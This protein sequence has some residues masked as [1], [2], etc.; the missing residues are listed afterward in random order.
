MKNLKDY[1][2]EGI[3]DNN[4]INTMDEFINNPFFNCYN[5]WKDYKEDSTKIPHD[6]LLQ[7]LSTLRVPQF[8]KLDSINIET[9]KYMK[10]H[11]IINI[12][13]GPYDKKQHRLFDLTFDEENYR[14]IVK[15]SSDNDEIINVY[16][17]FV[18][19]K[20]LCDGWSKI[21]N[22]KY[23]ESTINGSISKF[24]MLVLK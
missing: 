9:S 12:K 23:I 6:K 10:N 17:N 4:T 14:V 2:K 16:G 5:L 7:V 19:F 22:T 21:Y 8:I 3:L 11:I 20:R 1:I 13:G 24:K 15:F 18:L